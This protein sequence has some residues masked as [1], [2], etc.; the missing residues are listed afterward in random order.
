MQT[1]PLT[2]DTTWML[3]IF[4]TCF[5]SES[6]LMKQ[7]PELTQKFSFSVGVTIIYF[8]YLQFDTPSRKKICRDRTSSHEL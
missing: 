5:K 4:V 8:Q 2:K 7:I 3:L 6:I 1:L